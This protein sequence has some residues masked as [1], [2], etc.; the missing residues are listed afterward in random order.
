[1]AMTIFIVL[2]WPTGTVFDNAIAR[3]FDI[4]TGGI[5][6]FICAYVIFPS[7]VTINLPV[8]LTKTIKSN[9]DYA[10]QILVLP[11]DEFKEKTVQKNAQ[12]TIFCKK[13]IWMQG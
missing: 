13:I 6:A 3:L 7:R 12:I 2:V 9:I 4:V 1:M 10:K 5:I 11:P 8:Q